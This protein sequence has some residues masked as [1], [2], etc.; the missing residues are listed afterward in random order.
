MQ[1]KV[2]EENSGVNFAD[3]L[4]N[5]RIF[6]AYFPTNLRVFSLKRVQT[7][8]SDRNQTYSS[9]NSLCNMYT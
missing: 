4:G 9:R 5:E 6:L 2:T 8:Q 7:G 3:R 1:L